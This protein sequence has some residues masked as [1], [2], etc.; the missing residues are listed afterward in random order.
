MDELVL[1]GAAL[2]GTVISSLLSCLPALHI[3]NVAGL[4]VLLSVKAEGLFPGEVLA[5]FMLGLVVGYAVV[6]TI[7][8]IF[9]GAPDDSTLFVVLPGQRYLMERRGFEAS[10]LTGVGGLGGLVVLLLLAPAMPRLFPVVRAVVGPHLHWILGAILVYMVLSEWP[11][12]SDRGRGSLAKFF[13]AWRSLGVGLLTLLLSGLLGLVLF[14]SSLVPAEMA[15]QNLMPAF[16][17]LFAIPWVVQNL[18]SQAQVPVQQT[19]RSVDLSPGLI[20]RGVGA[21]ALGG[22]FAAFF[23]VVTGG[24]GGFLAGHATAQRDDRLF[25]VSQG[26]SKLVYYVGAFLFFFVPGLHLTRGG[27]AGMLS[28]LYTPY[29]PTTYWLTMAATLICGALA[30]GLLLVLSRVAIGLV[31]RVDY[32]WIS[33]GTLAV[34]IGVVAALTGW[35]GLLIAA[36]ATAIGL[37]PVLW[38]SRRMNCMGVLLVPL[39][40]QMAGLGTLAAGWLGLI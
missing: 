19:S 16:V 18:L 23:P 32:R 30:F 13:D 31:S 12:G 6:N 10:V 3:Y 15:F 7:P 27:M 2:A 4:M 22:L 34:L 38:G 1:I 39:T 28:I 35:G 36:V 33:A 14:Y 11:K 20:A 17:G 40:L 25:I 21:G 26:A 5:M 8:S 29:T 24:I 37:L 9:F